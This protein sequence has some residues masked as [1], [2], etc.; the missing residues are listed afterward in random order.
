MVKALADGGKVGAVFLGVG[1]PLA[2]HSLHAVSFNEVNEIRVGFVPMAPN[3]ELKFKVLSSSSRCP[4]SP[5]WALC[6]GG[7]D[8]R[9]SEVRSLS[10]RKT[11]SR[12]NSKKVGL[13]GV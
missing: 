7:E 3:G 10:T 12:E 13:A 4:W 8:Q 11:T 2:R 1:S 5:S 6:G 9:A